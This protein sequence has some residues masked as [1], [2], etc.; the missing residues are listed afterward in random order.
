MNIHVD[1]V[2]EMRSHLFELTEDET[3]E[4]KWLEASP[5][6]FT[7]LSSLIEEDLVKPTANLADLVRAFSRPSS[8]KESPLMLDLQMYKS[9]GIRDSRHSLQ[10]GVSMW[11]LSWI[12]FIFLPLT[13]IVGFFGMNVDTFANNPSIKWYFVSV[14]PFM[15]FVLGLWYLLKHMLKL[16]RQTQYQRGVYERLFQ[17]LATSYPV[18]WSRAGP[19]RTLQPASLVARLKWRLIRYWAAPEN[20]ILALDGAEGDASADGLSSWSRI[21]R[22]LMRKW[23]A[24]IT[25]RPMD[26]DSAAALMLDSASDLELAGAAGPSSP[27]SGAGI[28]TE[29]F[30]VP[31]TG[32]RRA[33][34]P[35]NPLTGLGDLLRIPRENS[36]NAPR[37]SHARAGSRVRP[38]SAGSGGDAGSDGEGSRP[39][40]SG[41]HSGVLVEEEQPDWLR[42]PSSD[43]D[44]GRREEERE[45]REERRERRGREGRASEH[46]A[47]PQE[48]HMRRASTGSI[49]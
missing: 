6:D 16:E 4:N 40:S 11:R 48:Q 19:R 5:E 27:G 29:L 10:L 17:D 47:P 37:R 25:L 12:T 14:V 7:R 18:L 34:L 21:K 43:E 13:F 3:L 24:Q 1:V 33:S 26:S 41:R 42:R 32:P 38:Q 31:V 44:W 9:V 30:A 45:E 35:T 23:T 22:H 20:T 28:H 15:L 49:T 2:K 39:T 46:D 36:P 8:A